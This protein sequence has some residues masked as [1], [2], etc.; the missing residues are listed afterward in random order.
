MPKASKGRMV[1]RMD[2]AAALW[3]LGV[4]TAIMMIVFWFAGV[5]TL[6]LRSL[7]KRNKELEGM[8]SGMIPLM[9]DY[10]YALDAEVCH[11]WDYILSRKDKIVAEEVRRNDGEEYQ[12]HEEADQEADR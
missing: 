3:I 2:E 10:M 4:L 9:E 5:R 1:R 7:K 11:L 8:L 12:K 6:T